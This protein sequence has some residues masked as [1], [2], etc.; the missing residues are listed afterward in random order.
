MVQQLL[1]KPAPYTRG[2]GICKKYERE[3]GNLTSL[4]PESAVDII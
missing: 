1:K 4:K 3:K 2:P